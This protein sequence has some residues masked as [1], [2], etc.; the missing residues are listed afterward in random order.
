MRYSP[1]PIGILVNMLGVVGVAVCIGD[2][3][4]C[5]SQRTVATCC[6]PER[7]QG[8]RT[9]PRYATVRVNFVHFFFRW[10]RTVGS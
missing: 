3:R 4:R 9:C 8:G 6:E 5:R 10:P 7:C 2:Q 1:I